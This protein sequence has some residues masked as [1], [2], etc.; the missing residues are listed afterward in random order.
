MLVL[1]LPSSKKS[2]FYTDLKNEQLTVIVNFVIDQLIYHSKTNIC[3]TQ[4]GSEKDVTN[5]YVYEVSDV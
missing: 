2:C 3:I 4:H 1:V 5:L